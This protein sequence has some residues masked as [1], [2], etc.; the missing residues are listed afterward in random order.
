MIVYIIMLFQFR[1]TLKLQSF[2]ARQM[3]ETAIAP[4]SLAPPAI[5]VQA[6]TGE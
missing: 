6:P 1:K 4:A 3:W 2:F 5:G